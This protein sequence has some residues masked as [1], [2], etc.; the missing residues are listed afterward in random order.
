MQNKIWISTATPNIKND[1][2]EELYRCFLKQKIF[3]NQYLCFWQFDEDDEKCRDLEK[4]IKPAK[5]QELTRQGSLG[6]QTPVENQ[7]R[8]VCIF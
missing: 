6:S 4:E 1:W 7:S 3:S 5:K 2:I 8:Q